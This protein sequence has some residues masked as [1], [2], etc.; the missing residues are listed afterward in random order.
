MAESP[1]KIQ[2]TILE[3][4]GRGY[5]PDHHESTPRHFFADEVKSTLEEFHQMK[6]SKA[7]VSYHLGRLGAAGKIRGRRQ[8]R[9]G[10]MSK[11]KAWALPSSF[12]P[13]RRAKPIAPEDV[14]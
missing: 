2:E 5:N 9:W 4:L 7:Q 1:E 13:V 11:A 3:A 8:Y 6:L 12:A 14:G 10:Y